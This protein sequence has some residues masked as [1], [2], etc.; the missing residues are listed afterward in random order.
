MPMLKVLKRGPLREPVSGKLKTL[1][2]GTVFETSEER[3]KKLL[4]IVPPVVEKT[5]E[6]AV[7]VTKE[8]D[9]KA[10]AAAAKKQAEKDSD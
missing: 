9:R 8:E 1:Y 2:P 6:K 10:K 3:A 4:K 7:K 5:S